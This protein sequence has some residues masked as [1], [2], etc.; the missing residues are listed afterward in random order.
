MRYL[1][2][3]LTASMENVFTRIYVY[4]KKAGKVKFA[5]KEYAQ[6]VNSA[7]AQDLNCVNVSM[8]MKARAVIFPRV[9]HPVSMASQNHQINASVILDGS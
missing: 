2:A 1:C 4:V 9:T 5:I 3:G 8:A 7:F 6:S